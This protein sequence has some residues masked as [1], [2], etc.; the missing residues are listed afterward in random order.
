MNSR[1]EKTTILFVNKES[2]YLKPLQISNNVVLNWKKY[3]AGMFLFFLCLIAAIVFL[4][5][6]N[7]QQ[8]K[9]SEILAQKINSMHIQL[10][11]VDSSSFRK[12][13]TNI[14]KQLSVINVFLKA[15]GIPTIYNKSMNENAG[16]EVMP[17]AEMSD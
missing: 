11:Q 10:E 17:V 3:L 14:D 13:L 15:R 6:N 12:K 9:T 2:Q 1:K 4:I 16:R 5:I 7:I 8:H